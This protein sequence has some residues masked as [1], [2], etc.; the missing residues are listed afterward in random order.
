[1]RD[2]HQEAQVERPDAGEARIDASGGRGEFA[3][4]R[5][6][7]RPAPTTSR[8]GP[9]R[10]VPH[11]K[12]EIVAAVTGGYLSLDEA[13]ERYAI[14]IE[15]FLAWQHGINLFGLAGLRVYGTQPRKGA[16]THCEDERQEGRPH[17]AVSRHSTKSG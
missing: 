11:R 5:P 1:M 15:E 4:D 14:S 9:K 17:R 10:W 2:I 12:A 8:S 7:D 13:R 6:S 3:N 16:K